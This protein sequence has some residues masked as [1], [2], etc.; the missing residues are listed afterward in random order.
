[1]EW[2]LASEK[3]N[4]RPRHGIELRIVE[5]PLIIPKHLQY[6]NVGNLD[7]SSFDGFSLTH[8]GEAPENGTRLAKM[9]PICYC[10][11]RKVGRSV[12]EYQIYQIRQLLA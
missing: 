4:N 3:K 11:R 5:L 12:S 9:G 1:M 7:L 10:S 2:L 6:Q 8:A